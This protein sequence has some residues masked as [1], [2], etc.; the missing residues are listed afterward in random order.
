[1]PGK[2]RGGSKDGKCSYSTV[3]GYRIQEAVTPNQFELLNHDII[4][5][6]AE[7]KFFEVK[8]KTDIILILINSCFT[9]TRLKV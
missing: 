9:Y 6:F 7:W 1:M 4:H 2:Y 8:N 5:R 3:N